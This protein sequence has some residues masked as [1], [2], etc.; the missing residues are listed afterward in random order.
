MQSV[1]DWL[2]DLKLGAFAPLFQ[3]NS[4]DMQ[5]LPLLTEDDLRE[6]GLPLGPRKIVGAAIEKLR[7]KPRGERRFLTTV[8]GDLVG[9]SEMARRLDPEDYESVLGRFRRESLRV[10]SEFGGFVADFAGDGVVAYFGWP[11]AFETQTEQALRAALALRDAMDEISIRVGISSGEVFVGST[12]IGGT[13]ERMVASGEAPNRAARLQGA[14]DPGAILVDDPTRNLIDDRFNL[15]PRPPVH[16][17]GFD[18][19]LTCWR[20]LSEKKTFAAPDT[21]PAYPMVERDRELD[22]LLAAWRD[23][24]N[25]DGGCVSISGDAGC[26]KSRLVGAF[27]EKAGVADAACIR[28]N[29]APQNAFSAF[30][31]VLSGLRAFVDDRTVDRNMPRI[32]SELLDGGPERPVEISAQERRRS[33]IRACVTLLTNH[34]TDRP[35]LVLAE[36]LHWIDPSSLDVLR[37]LAAA[38]NRKRLLLVTTERAAHREE[39]LADVAGETVRLDRLSDT[40]LKELVGSIAGTSLSAEA[41]EQIIDRADG[42][43][44]FAEQLALAMLEG[45]SASGE[46]S[47]PASLR[48]TLV[49]RLDRLGTNK[50]VAL[51]ASVI[52]R[53]FSRD[54]LAYISELSADEIEIGLQALLSAGLVRRVGPDYLF[55]HALVRDAAYS[56]LLRDDRRGMHKRMAAWLGQ[57]GD[58]SPPEVQAHHLQEAGDHVASAMKWERAA[59]AA[60]E[61][62]A[63]VEA[64]ELYG[65]A[66]EQDKIATGGKRTLDLLLHLGEAQ[67]AALGGSAEPTRATFRHAIA[68]AEETGSTWEHCTALYGVWIGKMI[69]GVFD[70]AMECARQMF[71]LADKTQDPCIRIAAL[72]IRCAPL[73]LSGDLDGAIADAET[74]LKIARTH[75]T[76][77]FGDFAHDPLTTLYPTYAQALWARGDPE[78]ALQIARQTVETCVASRQTVNTISYVRTWEVI[79][80]AQS[81]KAHDLAVAAQDLQR[82]GERTG[83]AFWENL[84]AWG[85]SYARILQGDHAEGTADAEASVDRFMSTGARQQAPLFLLAVAEGKLAAGQFDDTS[86]LIDRAEQIMQATN[87]GYFRPLLLRTKA[88]LLYRQG[89]PEAAGEMRGRFADAI[90]A[91]GAV[92]WGET[93]PTHFLR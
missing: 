11:E 29:C 9:S 73:G 92:T 57:H 83:G 62:Y 34:S 56:S 87:Q 79:L 16:A 5:S 20:L 60:R 10:I 90:K 51:S 35:V 3:A 27:H 80:L 86:D 13:H 50:T 75:D 91:T 31:P 64:A 63:Q 59:D 93:G 82:F 48:A 22:V 81:R 52:G 41:I 24:G 71:V 26:G 88:E 46:A 85:H 49:S 30:A 40:A 89:A 25:G 33:V 78:R 77:R 4:I 47:V 74:A 39:R 2:E 37:Q 58:D 69:T 84:G 19:P 43:P 36:D 76:S 6:I 12:E 8:F 15:A 45:V 1:D 21:P 72:R 23:A 66:L 7:A 67:F 14:A 70:E 28:I 54:A 44:L 38:I 17:K 68:L 61:R 55:S 42:I 53:R 18:T 65:R 32:L